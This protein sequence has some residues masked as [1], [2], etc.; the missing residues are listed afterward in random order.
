MRK[1]AR[2]FFPE[3]GVVRDMAIHV[4]SV[5]VLCLVLSWNHSKSVPSRAYGGSSPVHERNLRQCARLSEA[6]NIWPHTPPVCGSGHAGSQDRG[7]PRGTGLLVYCVAS[8]TDPASRP[9]GHATTPGSTA[10]AL[11][12]AATPGIAG[13][14]P[15]AS[16]RGERRL[17]RAGWSDEREPGDGD[18]TTAATIAAAGRPQVAATEA[19]P[20]PMGSSRPGGKKNR[21]AAR[22]MSPTPP[23]LE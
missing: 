21:V 17:R 12:V 9:C 2:L 23:S 4:E 5:G 15:R 8:G 19:S 20:R 22:P 10:P 16:T 7:A 14:T 18:A 1:V 3:E 13:M 6:R 11:A